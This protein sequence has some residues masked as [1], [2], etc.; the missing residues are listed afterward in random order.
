MGDETRV[1]MI[2]SFRL[3]LESVYT[4][5]THLS[6]VCYNSGMSKT[7]RFLLQGLIA[8]V[9][10]GL[11]VLVSVWMVFANLVFDPVGAALLFPLN[12]FLLWTVVYA[13][14]ISVN[15]VS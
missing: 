10:T 14:C 2:G 8:T 5:E 9:G 6:K 4:I 15:K 11:G 12:L 3:L 13:T 7:V 1:I